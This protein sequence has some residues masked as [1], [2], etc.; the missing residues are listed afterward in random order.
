L[1]WRLRGSLTATGD[2]PEENNSE[3]KARRPTSLHFIHKISPSS[4]S[5]SKS[6]LVNFFSR[7]E[8][9]ARNHQRKNLKSLKWWQVIS[10]QLQNNN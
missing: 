6:D 10:G 8:T 2:E 9:A 7:D 3:Y 1:I 4:T 5:A